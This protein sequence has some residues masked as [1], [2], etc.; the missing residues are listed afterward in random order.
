[1]LSELERKIIAAIQGDIP[2]AE[3]PYQQIA[4]RIGTDEQTVLSV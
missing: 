1:M 3:R 2:V 4:E